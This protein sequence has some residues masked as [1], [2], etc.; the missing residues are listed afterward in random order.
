MWPMWSHMLLSL[1]KL[2]S[3]KRNLKWKKVEKCAFDEI[4]RI[5]ARDTLLTYTDFNETF[6]THTD[7]STLQL[8]A[9]IIQKGKPIAFYSR[10]LTDSQQQYTATERELLSI[11]ENLKEF[12]KIILGQKLQIYTD[13]KNFMCK[14]FNT[15]RV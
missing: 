3:I 1:N 14:F 10:K 2:T 8:G 11:V 6:K 5:V 4:K 15:D 7:A 9:V 12:R 13:H